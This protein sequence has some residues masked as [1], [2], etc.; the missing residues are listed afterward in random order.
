MS[1]TTCAGIEPF[2]NREFYDHGW[3]CREHAWLVALLAEALGYSAVV[4]HGAATFLPRVPPGQA[5]SIISQTQHSWV[6]V[7]E[8]GLIDLSP[9]PRGQQSTGGQTAT[10]GDPFPLG[11]IFRNQVGRSRAN[12][13]ILV[14]DD[15]QFR[16]EVERLVPRKD[17]PHAVFRGRDYD[18]ILEDIVL[19]AVDWINSPLTGRLMLHFDRSIYAK[20]FLH[21]HSYLDH[22]VSSLRHTDQLGAWRRIDATHRDAE[23]VVIRLARVDT[24]T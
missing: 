8:F 21:L 4:M 22:R 6:G 11:S 10:W 3:S 5:R 13:V 7:E 2:D 14:I 20:A 12:S 23:D 1:Y 17:T 15:V 16:N 9:K 19:H 18:T 24:A